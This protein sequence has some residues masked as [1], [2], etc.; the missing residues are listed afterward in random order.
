MISDS[1]DL[2]SAEVHFILKHIEIIKLQEE[3]VRELDLKTN[4]DKTGKEKAFL[5]VYNTYRT[6]EKQMNYTSNVI[7]LYGIFEQFVESSIKEYIEELCSFVPR[8]DDLDD[9][10][11]NNYLNLW[12][13]FLPKLGW[14][15]FSGLNHNILV[16]NLYETLNEKRN[17]ILF[18]LFLRN[19][20]NYNHSSVS[21]LMNNIINSS[22]K[23]NIVKG[24]SIN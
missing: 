11:K 23:E 1:F 3:H 4:A 22:F 13:Q 12:T 7:F 8:Y 15:K 14:A 9:V 2:F 21:D 16:K 20:G 6:K 24:C 18:Q 10:I 17:N 5:G 19:G